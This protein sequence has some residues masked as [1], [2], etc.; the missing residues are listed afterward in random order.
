MT[1][2]AQMLR[3]PAARDLEYEAFQPWGSSTLTPAAPASAPSTDVAAPQPNSKQP[4][5]LRWDPPAEASRPETPSR[6][7]ELEAEVQR[8]RQQLS[9]PS[10][11]GHDHE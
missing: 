4:I 10:Y 2:E 6:E 5:V 3:R 11:S 7:A 9:P 8:L 1:D